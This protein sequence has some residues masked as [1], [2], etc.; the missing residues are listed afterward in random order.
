MVF[1]EQPSAAKW[2]ILGQNDAWFDSL[3]S[4]SGGSTVIGTNDV[5]ATRYVPLATAVS[6]VDTDPAATTWSSVDVTA[7]TS[8]RAFAAEL[9]VG[10]SSGTTIGREGYVRTTGSGAAQDNTTIAA[11]VQNTSSV[12]CWNQVTVPLDSSQSFDW[13]VSNADV[14]GFTVILRGYHEYV[15]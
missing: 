1:G 11:R 6:L 15:D 3:I 12:R 2:N 13:S 8:A 9:N 7:N 4:Q 5:R 10:I 14:N